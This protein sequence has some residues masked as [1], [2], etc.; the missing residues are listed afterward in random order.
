[1][2]QKHV[3]EEISS[4]MLHGIAEGEKK[5]TGEVCPVAGSPTAVV[6][7]GELSKSRM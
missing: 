7:R 6:V 2:A 1:M 3:G 4:K 5:V